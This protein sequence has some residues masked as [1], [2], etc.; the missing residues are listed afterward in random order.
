MFHVLVLALTFQAATG[1]EHGFVA[2]SR[3][4]TMGV[5]RFRGRVQPESLAM[6]ISLDSLTVALLV[7]RRVVLRITPLLAS[8]TPGQVWQVLASG[9]AASL[10]MDA[11][12]TFVYR[13]VTLRTPIVSA[14]AP[15]IVG[16]QVA[17]LS[18]PA[19]PDSIVEYGW[20]LDSVD[21]L[22]V[23]PPIAS[24]TSSPGPSIAWQLC[25]SFHAPFGTP[26]RDTAGRYLFTVV[27]DQAGYLNTRQSLV[28]A[29]PQRGFFLQQLTRWV[30]QCRFRPAEL[31][32]FRLRSRF[33]LPLIIADPGG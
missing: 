30:Y 10:H 8:R 22:S 19:S 4:P 14:P 20:A 24:D 16:F 32:G 7:P 1:Q 15:T 23:G 12:G 25:G 18:Q 27:L 11:A 13:G 9:E 2:E 33:L 29:A 26:S 31:D 3:A 21:A 5:V 28:D 6:R 17:W